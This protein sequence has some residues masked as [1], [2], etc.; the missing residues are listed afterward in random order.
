MTAAARA[1]ARK[2][3]AAA[4]TGTGAVAV[5]LITGTD[6]AAVTRQANSIIEKILPEDQRALGLEEIVPKGDKAEDAVAALK[7]IMLAASTG[8][9][10]SS[11]KVVW[12]RDAKFLK[13]SRITE[14]AAYKDWLGRLLGLIKTGLPSGHHLIITATA[15]DGR[16]ALAKLIA[17]RG[18]TATHD[19]ES[20]PWKLEEA[21]RDTA[22]EALKRAGLRPDARAVETF[23]D[24]VGAD[25]GTA[26]QEAEK[27]ATYLAGGSGPTARDV[28]DIVSST[29][30]SDAFALADHLSMRR[31]AEAVHVLR[32]LLDQGEDPIGLLMMLESRWRQLLILRD[33]VER[34][35]LQ[36][37]D[38]GGTDWSGAGPEATAALDALDP[39]WDPRKTNPYRAKIMVDQSRNFSARELAR[40][41]RDLALVREQLVSGGAL[42]DV[43]L[44]LL[45]IRL[46]RPAKRTRREASV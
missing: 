28:E 15:V 11:A 8:S 44:E 14:H 29:R 13:N 42:P 35:W 31:T 5:Y 25:S 26:A 27:L 39:R 22:L 10:F 3:S 9:F 18:M 12:L 1:P 37:R 24:R 40:G 19:V 30:N 20:R 36:V 33:A 23:A 7:E 46:A 21:A 6:D 43:R 16:S 34:G 4:D 38:Y 45:V 32:R 41:L 17:A 2:P